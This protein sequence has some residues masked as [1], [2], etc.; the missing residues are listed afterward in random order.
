MMPVAGFFTAI[1]L[2]IL[3]VGDAAVTPEMDSGL[4]P[5]TG[6]RD[7]VGIYESYES[8][9]PMPDHLKT[10]DEMVAWMTKELPKLTAEI[11]TPVNPLHQPRDIRDPD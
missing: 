1:W 6:V 5:I 11:S 10:Q 8:Y 2:L 9:I 3:W 7:Q 4:D